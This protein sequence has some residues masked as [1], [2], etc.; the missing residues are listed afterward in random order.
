MGMNRFTG[1]QYTGKYTIPDT[2]RGSTAYVLFGMLYTGNYGDLITCALAKLRDYSG[3]GDAHIQVNVE[4]FVCRAG[5]VAATC[6]Y[7]WMDC[8]TLEEFRF[9]SQ[10]I[11]LDGY[12]INHTFLPG[13]ELV[14]NDI[15]IRPMFV[16]SFFFFLFVLF[17]VIS[18]FSVFLIYFFSTSVFFWFCRTGKHYRPETF[19][20]PDLTGL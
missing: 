3:L 12:V 10:N 6:V 20:T 19:A 15:T 17:S 13:I 2:F 7:G 18:F 16:I 8:T 14:H 5:I 11:V 9:T 1:R 4:Y